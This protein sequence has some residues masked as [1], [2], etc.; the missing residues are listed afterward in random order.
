MNQ[1]RSDTIVRGGWIAGVAVTDQAD[2][3]K[4]PIGDTKIQI[5]ST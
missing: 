1:S 3:T 2:E 4:P 5:L